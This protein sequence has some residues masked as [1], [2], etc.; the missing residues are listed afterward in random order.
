MPMERTV[1]NFD[2]QMHSTVVAV[3]RLVRRAF[4]LNQTVMKPSCARAVARGGMTGPQVNSSERIRSSSS[5][6]SIDALLRSKSNALRAQPALLTHHK[7]S[8]INHLRVNKLNNDRP[9]K[10]P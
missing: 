5:S 2:F 3:Q 4:M 9:N 7:H 6:K 8:Q 10:R 1:P